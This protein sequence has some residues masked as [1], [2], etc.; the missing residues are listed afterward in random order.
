IVLNPLVEVF[1]AADAQIV[2][3]SITT[4]KVE[5][6]AKEILVYSAISALIIVKD[7]LV[8]WAA[9]L[10]E[11][12]VKENAVPLVL[13]DLDGD[14]MKTLVKQ[15]EVDNLI[16]VFYDG[17]TSGPGDAEVKRFVD[18]H[19]KADSTRVVWPFAPSVAALLWDKDIG[20][21][22]EIARRKQKKPGIAFDLSSAM[23]VEF[24]DFGWTAA[25][26]TRFIAEPLLWPRLSGRSGAQL[27]PSDASWRGVLLREQ[28]MVLDFPID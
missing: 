18:L 23:A 14:T 3:T 10:N 22:F 9:K 13:Q 8:E 25:D 6:T 19:R 26:R 4:K 24:S 7:R 12:F 15:R 21:G 20:Y 28:P 2:T 16:V 17:D 27:D 11:I 1:A 5:G